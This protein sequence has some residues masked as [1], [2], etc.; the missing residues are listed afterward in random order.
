MA[1][2][3]GAMLVISATPGPSDFAVVGRSVSAGIGA[4]ATMIAGIVV[5]D[6][7]F[8]AL[9]IYGMATA[10]EHF[11]ALFEAIR[12][13]CAIYLVWLGVAALR[14][15]PDA[16]AATANRGRLSGFSAGLMITLGDP[17]AIL[18]YMSLL[19]AFVDLATIS[20]AEVLIV[21]A[22]ATVVVGGV[23][24]VY[25]VLAERAV[26]LLGNRDTRRRMN[27]VAG[28]VLIATVHSVGMAGYLPAGGAR[29]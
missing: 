19:P 13:A 11:G 10:A 25:A 20:T 18:F 27:I 5:A 1:A 9:A 12:L 4:A 24:A 29:S 2:L 14:A 7:L 22:I 28:L 23:K 3:A 16:P 21:M 26:V 17:K 6:Y 15:R 8:I